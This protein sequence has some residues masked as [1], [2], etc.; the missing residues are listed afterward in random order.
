MQLADFP[1][2]ADTAEPMTLA[3][4]FNWWMFHQGEDQLEESD[5]A[6]PESMAT[7]TDLLRESQEIL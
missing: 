1:T 5:V 2:G 4:S 6:G 3:H 7:A